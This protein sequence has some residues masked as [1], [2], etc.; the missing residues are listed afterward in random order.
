MNERILSGTGTFLATL[1]S[2]FLIF[3][4]L[5][6]EPPQDIYAFVPGL[7]GREEGLTTREETVPIGAFFEESDGIPSALSVQWPRFRGPGYDNRSREVIPLLD[8]WGE[9]GP[10][11]LWN[12]SLGEGHGAP[13]VAN[14]CVYILDYDEEKKG[15]ALRCLSLD[16][17]QEIWRRW[18]PVAVKRNHGMSRTVPAVTRNW[19]VSIGPRCHVMCVNAQTGAFLWGIDLEKEYGTT[20]PQWYTAQCPV[21]DDNI[22]VIAPAGTSLM[23]G[24]DC[25]TGEVIWETPNH[26]NWKMSH[27]SI[28][29]GT[30][31]GVKMYVYAALGGICGIAAQGDNR[32]EILWSTNKW[33]NAVIAPSPVILQD[34][35][36][37][38]TAGYGAGSMM[39]KVK[40]EGNEFLT[41][42]LYKIT[43]REGLS[44]EQQTPLLY[45]GHLF[46][47]LT[48]DAGPLRNQFTCYHP[49]GRGV[50]SFADGRITWSSGKDK[51]FGLGPYIIADDKFFILSDDGI[52]TIARA[53]TGSYEELDQAK[54]FDGR[55]A[56]GPLALAGG[57]LL[58]RDTKQLVCINMTA[59]KR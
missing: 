18:Y 35:R 15:D 27:S 20:V 47:I 42:V 2:I 16:N 6:S 43:P 21:I 14:G 30:I 24:K 59:K 4:W 9:E 54:I 13:A 38:L 29:I 23:I 56:W 51:R 7:D 57:R 40:K 11:V 50:E 37:F 58:A 26:N 3:W 33:N 5:R 10:D 49:G 25:R 44:C 12:I 34:N 46:G 19:V 8:H 22:A 48:K 39:L 28:I 36:I 52:L 32:G 45:N 31:H 1:L 55:D 17:G 41:E 53:S